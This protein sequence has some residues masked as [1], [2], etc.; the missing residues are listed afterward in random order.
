MKRASDQA[1]PREVESMG[2]EKG[3]PK[4]MRPS[5]QRVWDVG[6]CGGEE[7]IHVGEGVAA[8]ARGRVLEP[9]RAEEGSAR[10]GEQ[11]QWDIGYPQW[12]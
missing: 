11:W 12:D 8:V 7:H 5:V 4:G 3:T 10:G 2:D 9:R 6:A 1:K